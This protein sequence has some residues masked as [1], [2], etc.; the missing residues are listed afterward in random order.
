MTEPGSRPGVGTRIAVADAGP[1]I[2]LDELACLNLLTDFIEVRVPESVWREVEH[3]RP[4][5]LLVAGIPWIRCSARTSEK[6]AAVGMLYTLHPGEREALSLCV[7]TP[8]VLLLTDDTAA[9]LAART[10]AID[11]HG[12]LGLL[13]RAIRRQQMTKI[14]VMDRLREIPLRTSLHIRPALLAEVIAQVA[15]SDEPKPIGPGP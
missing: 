3:H 15:K 5:A 11:A 1:L 12:T 10:L 9:R 14:E 2:H 6:V 7:D 13:V 8:G 4:Q